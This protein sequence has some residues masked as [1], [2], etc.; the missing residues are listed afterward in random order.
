MKVLGRMD[1]SRAS[2]FDC[3]AES[4]EHQLR[5]AHDQGTH[6]LY[7]EVLKGGT[8]TKVYFDF[9]KYVDEAPLDFW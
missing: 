2:A 6:L 8:A 7:N 3:T 9:D 1:I 4:L 5:L